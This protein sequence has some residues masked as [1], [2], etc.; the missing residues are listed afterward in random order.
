M[1]ASNKG[2]RKPWFYV[3]LSLA[4]SD[5]HGSGIAQEVV[6]LSEGRIRL[7]PVALYGSLQALCERGAIVELT[8]ASDRP[9]SATEKQR[10]YRIT[11]SGRAALAEEARQMAW[12]ANEALARSAPSAKRT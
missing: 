6:S 8:K 2:L 5:L 1:G 4:G 9:A 12:L 7:W 10:Y 11:K 3:L